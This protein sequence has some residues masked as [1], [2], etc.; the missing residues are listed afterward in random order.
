MENA[1]GNLGKRSERMKAGMRSQI[2][3]RKETGDVNEI[4]EENT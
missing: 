3:Q 4:S 2:D 1:E